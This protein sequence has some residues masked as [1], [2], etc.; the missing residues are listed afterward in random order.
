MSYEVKYPNIFTPV[1]VGMMKVKNRIQFSPIV[2]AHAETKSG[3]CTEGLI[4]FVGAQARSGAG[5]V[6]IG[7]SPIDFDRAR[8]F[9]GCLSVTRDSDI[10]GMMQ[11]ADEVHRYGAK[12]SVELTHAGCIGNPGLLR[13]KPALVPSVI[14]GVHDKMHV[15][16]IDQSEM[17]EVIDRWTDCVRRCCAAGFDMAMIHGAHGNLLSSFMSLLL[18]TRTDEYGGSPEN[19]RRFPLE[20]LKAVRRAAGNKLAIELRISGDERV[21]GGTTFEERAA[22]LQ[23]AQ[24]YI[25]MVVISTGGFLGPYAE[26]YMIPSYYYPHMLNVE[27][28]ARMKKEL[29]IPVSVAGGITSV[30]EAEQILAEGKADIVAMARAL[31]A[32]QDL[33]RKAW[34]G[35]QEEIRPC[36]RCMWCL[37]Y[38]SIGVPIRCAVNP[39]A[40]REVRYGYIPKAEVKKKVMVIGGGP[41]GMTAA[42]TLTKRGHDVVIYEREEWLGGRL[43]EA[44]ALWCKDGFR[45]YLVWAV[46][47]TE[48][49]GARIVTGTFVTPA[50]I[51]KEE[52]DAVI[53]A[54]GAEEIHL[55]IAG[56]HGD[57]VIS[58]VECERG[59][60]KAGKRVAVCGGGLS[61]CE[62]ALH[63]ARDGCE[64][65]VLE[66][67]KESESCSDS[68]AKD[69]L[70]KLMDD[71]GVRRVYGA[72]VTAF[73]EQGVMVVEDGS[74]VLYEADTIVTAFGLRPAAG[75][76]ESLLSVV[77]DTWVVGDANSPGLIADANMQA[78]NVAVEI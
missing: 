64:V 15:K 23:E 3:A 14:P 56:T 25:D 45:Q 2:S 20:L 60:R 7:S 65:T 6:T 17:R 37:N 72:R 71:Y 58:V 26:S 33:I 50:V 61:G 21:E 62:C 8:N 35:K 46:Q 54:V 59:T 57:N 36:L 39:R 76:I 55:P 13:G 74:M 75:V 47:E 51:E 73:S 49:C 44:G 27:Y 52:P 9:Y 67:A 10:P 68:R 77:P 43:Y 28:A 69:I 30:D 5:I 48:K 4:R 40:G 78:F 38:T 18:N 1:R 53:I 63:L 29:E 70:F 11:L 22:F 16:E 31:I 12:I 19:R 41:A 24:K 42:R 32:D 66:M 34:H